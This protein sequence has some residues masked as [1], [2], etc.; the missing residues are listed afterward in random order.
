M[1]TG[2]RTQLFTDTRPPNLADLQPNLVKIFPCLMPSSERR[3]H[4]GKDGQERK[5]G[6]IKNEEK[7][8][9]AT[10]QTI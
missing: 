5:D 10:S 7:E 8:G 4:G 9:E 1:G 3:R 6:G 2:L